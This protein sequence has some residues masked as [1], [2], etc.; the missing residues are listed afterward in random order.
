M[1]SPSAL[2]MIAPAARAVPDVALARRFSVAP[3]MDGVS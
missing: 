1:N 2:S 3:M